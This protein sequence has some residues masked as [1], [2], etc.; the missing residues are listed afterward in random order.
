MWI[1]KRKY[2]QLVE[3]IRELR[4]Q[5]RQLRNAHYARQFGPGG[6][7]ACMP[8]DATVE[9]ILKHLHL[10]IQDQPSSVLKVEEGDH[11]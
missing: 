9:A 7:M 10:K 4:S 8:L 5:V 2:N 3:D 6:Y 1:R 11:D